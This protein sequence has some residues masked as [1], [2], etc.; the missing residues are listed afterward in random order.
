MK[1]VR[2]FFIF[3]SCGKCHNEYPHHFL[4]ITLFKSYSM[5]YDLKQSKSLARYVVLILDDDNEA[6]HA[7][8]QMSKGRRQKYN[9]KNDRLTFFPLG[10]KRPLAFKATKET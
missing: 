2:Y 9:W 7:W 8:I 3:Y 1:P 4:R 5:V 6:C 10:G